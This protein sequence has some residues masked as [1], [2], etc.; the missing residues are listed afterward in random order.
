M[1]DSV[2]R[3]L[4]ETSAV[5]G[6]EI[7][8]TDY[9]NTQTVNTPSGG[10]RATG[11]FYM[12]VRHAAS[13]ALRA[14]I[15]PRIQ[16]ANDTQ[17]C[18]SL[19]PIGLPFRQWHWRLGSLYFPHQPIKGKDVIEALPQ[20]YIY[21]ADAQGKVAGAPR[22]GVTFDDYIS[23]Y[24]RQSSCPNSVAGDYAINTG[25]FPNESVRPLSTRI[26]KYDN[27]AAHAP[28]CVSLERSTLF[29]L[30]GIPINNSRVLSFHGEFDSAS[31]TDSPIA[32]YYGQLTFDV[33]LQYVRLARVF[34]N[35]VE[36]EQ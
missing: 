18:D 32:P 27:F 19:T 24:H 17:V 34:L 20:T 6:L 25:V 4:N 31:G 23:P 35:N 1:T 10:G 26:E 13:R 8:Y 33:Y 3:I 14:M 36:V 15:I 29:N 28:I 5:N 30:S 22:C 7:V 16:L 21:T 9:N 11:D 2:Q 12:E